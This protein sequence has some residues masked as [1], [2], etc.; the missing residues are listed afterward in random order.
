M[1]YN[2]HSTKVI[3]RPT[4]YPVAISDLK[5]YLRVDG[6]AD[7]RLI[8]QYLEAATD[9]IEQYCGRYF[10][11][12]TVELTM[13]GFVCSGNDRSLH[14]GFYEGH[15]ASFIGQSGEF[16]LPFRPVQSVTS[17]TTY[18][19]DNAASVF[20]PSSYNLDQT[21]GRVY[22]NTGATWPTS[23]RD[24]AGIKVVYVAGYGAT[25]ASVPAAIKQAIMMHVAKMYECRDG[26][27]LTDACKR[28]LDGYRILDGLGW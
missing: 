4:V 1:K 18:D 2:R 26:C 8:Q 15:K 14:D 6:C 5:P 24:R 13:D 16:D 28:I 3:T 27:D 11:S 9:A 25:A 7:D 20:D 21:S 19:E 23:L 22:L 10:I 12:T 17:I